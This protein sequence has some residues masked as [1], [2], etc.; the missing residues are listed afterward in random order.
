MWNTRIVPFVRGRLFKSLVGGC[1]SGR[2]LFTR[3][4]RQKN[5]MQQLGNAMSKAKEICCLKQK[6]IGEI[7][8]EKERIN[9]RGR[10]AKGK[11]SV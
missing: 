2:T 5:K 4:R 7:R 8:I 9:K 3:K 11:R 6:A 10:E 1:L